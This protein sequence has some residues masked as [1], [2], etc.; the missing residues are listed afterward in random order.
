[1]KTNLLLLLT[2]ISIEFTRAQSV[3]LSPDKDNTLYESASGDV[4]NGAGDYLFFGQTNQGDL[5]RALISFDVAS[6]L[7]PGDSVTNVILRFEVSK[8]PNNTSRTTNIHTVSTDWGEGSSN[9]GGEEGTGTAASTGDATWTMAFFGGTNPIPWANAG[10]DFNPTA[11]G[12]VDV[13]GTGPYSASSAQMIADVQDWLNNP[14]NNNGWILIGVEGTNAS[15]KRIDSRENSS[16]SL[17]L[18]IDFLRP[19]AL[20]SKSDLNKIVSVFPNPV[21][22]SFEIKSNADIKNVEVLDL[23]GKR[24]KV[25]NPNTKLFDISDLDRGIYLIKMQIGDNSI[26]QKLIKN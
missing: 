17:S 9:A 26:T 22:S 15:A 6:A 18:Q 25:L 19:V 21:S 20:N 16:N 2:L 23:N 8:V 4:S 3:T 10:G 7:Q 13:T 24:R 5:R 11:S 12:S 14:S 1:M